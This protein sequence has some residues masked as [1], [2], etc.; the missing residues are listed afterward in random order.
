MEYSPTTLFCSAIVN[1]TQPPPS[2]QPRKM[3]MRGAVC[4]ANCGEKEKKTSAFEMVSSPSL[5]AI[6]LCRIASL[7]YSKHFCTQKSRRFPVGFRFTHCADTLQYQKYHIQGLRRFDPAHSY[8][9][10]RPCSCNNYLNPATT[11]GITQVWLFF[12][13]S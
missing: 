5:L 3:R 10:A 12:L 4:E 11:L 8:H 9:T 7:F 1:P 13:V 2:A 6:W